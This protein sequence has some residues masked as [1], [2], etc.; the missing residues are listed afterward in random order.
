MGSFARVST[1][2][3]ARA[4]ACSDWRPRQSPQFIRIELRTSALGNF[5][6]RAPETARVGAC[7][8]QKLPL[9]LNHLRR[10]NVFARANLAQQVFAWRVVEIQY[11]ERGTAGLIS[12]E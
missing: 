1:L 11:R 4:L 8:P 9:Q 6:A 3:S 10:V 2:G 12:A 7:A 5:P